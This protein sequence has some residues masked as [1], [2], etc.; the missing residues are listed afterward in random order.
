MHMVLHVY[1]VRNYVERYVTAPDRN[2]QNQPVETTSSAE[3]ARLL[4][5]S[6]SSPPR[7]LL[8][9]LPKI[10][11]LIIALVTDGSCD[12]HVTEE[13]RRLATQCGAH[14]LSSNSPEW[15]SE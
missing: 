9:Q 1:I 4:T 6:S 8:S 2:K 3:A 13:G 15:G 10:P 5:S 14:F 12:S 7:H 11:I